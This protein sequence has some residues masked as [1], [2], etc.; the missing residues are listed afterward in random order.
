MDQHAARTN[1]YTRGIAAF[2]AG[3]TYD[4]VPG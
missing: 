3:L 2:T 1:E 4:A